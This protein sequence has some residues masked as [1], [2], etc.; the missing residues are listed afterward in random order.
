MG[1]R[2]T[3][4]NIPSSSEND[5]QE[6]YGFLPALETS[7]HLNACHVLGD[8]SL[9]DVHFSHFIN[10]TIHD[11]TPGKSLPAATEFLLGFSV[12]F[13]LTPNKSLQPNNIDEGIG[14]LNNDMFL[15]IHFAGDNE[16]NKPYKKL[17]VKSTWK[18]DQPPHKILSRLSRF[19]CTL[20][21]QFIP[22]CRKSNL[23]KFQAG[24]LENVYNNKNVI[25]ALADKNLG[26]ARV[27]SKQYIQWGIKEH[28]L[29]PAR[30]QLIS[31][32]Y[33]RIAADELYTTISQWTRTHSI[34]NLLTK[35]CRKYIHQKIQDARSDPFEIH[36]TPV[37]TR[38]VCSNLASLPH[39]LGQW[40]DLALQP[41]V[42]SQPTYFK[43]SFDLKCEFNTLV[44]PSNASLF[45]QCN[46]NVHQY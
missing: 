14:C 10:K 28:L 24:I 46:L 37:S 41:V 18:L 6:S 45:T 13:I 11:L 33:A 16:F 34:C 23:T 7:I 31:K 25:F 15:K 36:K 27:D 44:I 21:N 8:M 35:D 3:Y 39:S 26:S 22:Q 17:Q 4:A 1:T 2:T 20:K 32:V 9:L 42:T 40:V 38:P 29:D 5:I 12:K 30:Y 43:D 19:E